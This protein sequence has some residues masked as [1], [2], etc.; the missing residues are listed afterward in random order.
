MWIVGRS[1]GRTLAVVCLLPVAG[2]VM[3]DFLEGV[4]NEETPR[5]RAGGHHR[6]RN[7]AVRELAGP[8][9]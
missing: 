7:V 2:Q 3:I 1:R 5:W 4:R 9:R 6:F 8:G